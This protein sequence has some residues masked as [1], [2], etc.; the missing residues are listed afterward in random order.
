MSLALRLVN[1]S[2]EAALAIRTALASDGVTVE[3][4]IAALR[5]VKM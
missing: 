4:V 2:D 5:E 3:K 1:S